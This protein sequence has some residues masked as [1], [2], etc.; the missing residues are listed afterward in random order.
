MGP[1]SSLMKVFDKKLAMPGL[2]LKIIANRGDFNDSSPKSPTKVWDK[3][4]NRTKR[5]NIF[6]RAYNNEHSS[7]NH[8]PPLICQGKNSY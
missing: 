1:Q 3:G 8:G 5:S 2:G 7:Q 6:Y 4:P